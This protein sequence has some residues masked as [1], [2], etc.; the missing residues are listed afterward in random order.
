MKFLIFSLLHV[1][2]FSW[3]I[4]ITGNATPNN[5]LNRIEPVAHSTFK[6]LAAQKENHDKKK[7]GQ[8]LSW[9]KNKVKRFTTNVKSLKN[10]L[11]KEGEKTTKTHTGAIV[12]FIIGFTS[13]FIFGMPL[14]IISVII[15]MVTLTQIKKNP[16]K[17]FRQGLS[18]SWN[19]CRINLLLRST[20]YC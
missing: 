16:K 18:S 8:L 3:L 7:L 15:G 13:I 1:I 14:G 9:V 17:H 20:Y 2:L 19:N 5:T 10:L 11:T 4:T 6:P 12:S